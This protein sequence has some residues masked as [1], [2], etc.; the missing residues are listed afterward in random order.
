M[1]LH[2]ASVYSIRMYSFNKIGR[3]EPSK[4]LTVS[5]EEAGEH[6]SLPPLPRDLG[7]QRHWGPTPF[8][9]TGFVVRR[10]EERCQD[11]CVCLRVAEGSS[12][13]PFSNEGLDGGLWGAV[14]GPSPLLWGHVTRSAKV[15][16]LLPQLTF[17]DLCHGV[18]LEI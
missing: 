11:V 1:D 6:P 15:Q 3:S 10:E 9:G 4:E 8:P 2:P 7:H 16:V 12:A 14:H 17:C 13:W 18:F 5:T